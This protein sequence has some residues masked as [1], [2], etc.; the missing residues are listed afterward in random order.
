[1]NRR[2]ICIGRGLK[3]GA[4]FH[5][6]ERTPTE[7]NNASENNYRERKELKEG[8]FPVEGRSGEASPLE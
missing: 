8:H 2:A 3:D 5:S 1:M 4:G 7:P 6:G